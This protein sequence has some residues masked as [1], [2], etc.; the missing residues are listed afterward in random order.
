MSDCPMRL[1][2]HRAGAQYIRFV[3]EGRPK[4]ASELEEMLPAIG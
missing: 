3:A 2:N 1:G 4:E